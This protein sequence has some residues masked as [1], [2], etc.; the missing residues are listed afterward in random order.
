MGIEVVDLVDMAHKE[1]RRKNIFDTPP[2]SRLDALLRTR[3]E[4][5]DALPQRRPN[6]CRA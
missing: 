6:L 2:F 4:G 1:K 5:F 3:T